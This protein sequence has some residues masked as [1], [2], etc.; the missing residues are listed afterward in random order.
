[1]AREPLLLFVAAMALSG[2]ARAEAPIAN[3]PP[4]PAVPSAAAAPAAVAPP[5]AANP[6]FSPEERA[7]LEQRLGQVEAELTQLRGELGN[8]AS[9]LVPTQA[10]PDG[11]PPTNGADPADVSL[12]QEI[13][14]PPP[15]PGFRMPAKLPNIPLTARFGNGFELKSEDD[16]WVF[17]FHDLTQFDGRFYTQ[18]DQTA[19][20]VRDSF[21]FPRQWYIFNGRLT[22]PFEYYVS[23]AE[24]FDTLN[25]LDVFLNIHYDDRLQLKVGRFK[26]PYTYEFYIGPIFGLIN[27]ERSVFFNNFGLNRDLGIMPWGQLFQKRIDYAFGVFNGNRN[28]F[29]D[30]NDAKDVVGLLNFKPWLLHEGSCLQ[31]LN[32]GGSFD[33]GDQFGT[34]VPRTFRTIVATTGNN[35]IGIPFLQL[36]DTVLEK[37]PRSLG[38]LHAAWYYKQLSAISEFDWGSVSYA[39]TNNPNDA[40]SLPVYGWYSQVGYFLTGE[41]VSGRGQ[42][43]PIHP[44]DIRKG[45]CGIGAWEAFARYHYLNIDRRVFGY[46]FADQNIW[47]NQLYLVDCGFNWYWT[48]NLKTVFQWEHAEFGNPVLFGSNGQKQ[49]NSDL[50][51]MRF[52]IYF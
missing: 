50:F 34:P 9:G 19:F 17:Q 42:V 46:N 22:K 43:S 45:R 41:T 26:T 20:N 48:Q 31:N 32:F 15:E 14:A 12:T 6:L 52:Q 11:G 39:F 23:I 7:A 30:Q 51:L 13:A 40:P 21:V 38:S 5:A 18:R 2:L 8:N 36:R 1:M 47:T 24:G 29:I 4:A 16:E 44:L 49:I 35:I 37:G 25:I 27:P 28:G 33:Y 3:P 10:A